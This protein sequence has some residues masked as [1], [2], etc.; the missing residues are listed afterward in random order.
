MA[1][2]ERSG[3][4]STSS[5]RY[6]RDAVRAG[7]GSGAPAGDI[8]PV[9]MPDRPSHWT[10]SR[11]DIAR[12][13]PS[14]LEPRSPIRAAAASHANEMSPVTPTG[15]SA[16]DYRWR[17]SGSWWPT[18]STQAAVT[19]S[20]ADC[21]YCRE[22]D[23]EPETTWRGRGFIPDIDVVLGTERLPGPGGVSTAS[24]AELASTAFTIAAEC[25]IICPRRRNGLPP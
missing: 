19:T 24:R 8:S 12:R 15:S 21:D 14:M 17:G 22:I 4:S 1:Q 7:Y 3:S 13:R 18:D 20:T 10:L 11:M 16:I 6:R 9:S 23:L 5:R 2:H 25:R